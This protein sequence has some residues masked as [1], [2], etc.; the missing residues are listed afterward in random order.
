MTD[1]Q[2]QPARLLSLDILRGFDLFMLV[3]FQPVLSSL[4]KKIDNP[5]MNS[6]LYHFSHEEWIGF[7]AWDIVMPLFLFMAGVAMPFALAK[8]RTEKDKSKVYK[9]ILK[10]VFLLFVL[11]AIVQ[12]NLLGLDIHKFYPYSNTLQAIAVG[13]LITAVFVMNFSIRGQIIGAIVLMLIYWA[14]MTFLGDFTPD[15]NFAEKVDR[16]V[17]GRFRD[18]AIWNPDGTWSFNPHYHYT[19]IWSSLTFGVT[20]LMGALAGH[21]VKNGKDRNKNAFTLFAVGVACIVIALV[22]SIQMPIIKKIW[23]CSMTLYSGGICFVLLSLFYYIIDCRNYTKGL[24]WLKIYG[25]NSITAYVIGMTINFR[26]VVTSVSYGLEQYLNNYY[27]VWITLGNF[28]IVFIILKILYNRGI[29]LK[30]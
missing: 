24:M 17:L 19:W 2:T 9:R 18:G 8:Y 26:S 5:F 4:A 29:F 20:V 21:I 14:P 7:R 23:T 27:A 28:I 6:L 13:Y 22:W 25:M 10:R 11:G 3:F 12:G 16:F 30:V 15:G 1:T